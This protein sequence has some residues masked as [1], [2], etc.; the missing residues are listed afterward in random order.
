MNEEVGDQVS[1]GLPIEQFDP[2]SVVQPLVLDERGK[3]EQLMVTVSTPNGRTRR[4]HHRPWTLREV[5]TLVE[6]VARC[7]GG[8]WADIKKLAFST[9]GYRTAVDLKVLFLG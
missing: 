6:G 2:S 8:K 4:K 9:V 7:G 5:M 1:T 3:T